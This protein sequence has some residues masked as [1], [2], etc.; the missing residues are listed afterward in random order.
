MIVMIYMMFLLA[1]DKIGINVSIKLH[2]RLSV[3]EI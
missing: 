2:Y 3:K 1:L